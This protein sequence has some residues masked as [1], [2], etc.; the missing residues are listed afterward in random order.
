MIDEAI[1]QFRARR[2]N[3]NRYRSLLQTNLTTLERDFIERRISEE[4]AA[5]S[6]LAFGASPAD[7]IFRG[8]RGE[9]IHTP[10]AQ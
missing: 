1:A 2:Q 8:H 3:I 9:P 7:A 4:E 5:I 6:V 10:D